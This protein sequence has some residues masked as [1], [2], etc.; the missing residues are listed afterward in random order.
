MFCETQAQA[1]VSSFSRVTCRQNRRSSSRN[2]SAVRLYFSVVGRLRLFEAMTK[3]G[4]ARAFENFMENLSSSSH[5][6][7]SHPSTHHYSFLLMFNFYATRTFF[8]CQR[9]PLCFTFLYLEP[10]MMKSYLA[11]GRTRWRSL[12]QS[13]YH[14][15]MDPSSPPNSPWSSPLW[16]PTSP[17]CKSILVQFISSHFAMS[18]LF[19][20]VLIPFTMPNRHS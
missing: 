7:Y 11:S 9:R 14:I 19:T 3:L 8:V 2:D 20:F 16:H 12:A 13:H 18:L 15:S 6:R 5:G 17:T 1:Q 10:I 4:K